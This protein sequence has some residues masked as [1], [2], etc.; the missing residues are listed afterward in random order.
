MIFAKQWEKE[1]A[2]PCANCQN[3][4]PNCKT[5]NRKVSEPCGLVGLISDSMFLALFI[6]LF[7]FFTFC[8][9]SS[10]FFNRLKQEMKLTL[11]V[12]PSHRTRRSFGNGREPRSRDFQSSW[13]SRLHFSLYP[14]FALGNW[15]PRVL[16][17]WFCSGHNCGLD[18][19]VLEDAQGNLMVAC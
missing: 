2:Y 8:Y 10:C 11:R 16:S 17:Q 14:V 18:Q 5:I 15:I 9:L 12:E 4:Y 6:S 3:N 13:M 1:K 19:I 7:L